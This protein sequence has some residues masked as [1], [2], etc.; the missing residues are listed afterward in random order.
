MFSKIWL[1]ALPAWGRTYNFPCK[2]RPKI[3]FTCT[4]TPW[5]RLCTQEVKYGLSIGTEGGD[6]DWPWRALWPLFHRIR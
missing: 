3:F 6:R 5:L 4:C 1:L 2:L